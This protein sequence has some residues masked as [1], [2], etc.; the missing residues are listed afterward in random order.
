MTSAE[1]FTIF[2]LSAAIGLIAGL[3]IL[4]KIFGVPIEEPG[5]K[6]KFSETRLFV[7]MLILTFFV[8]LKALN[9][10][11]P[12]FFEFK[13]ALILWPLT[14]RMH[15]FVFSAYFGQIIVGTMFG[16]FCRYWFYRGRLYQDQA[17]TISNSLDDAIA[18]TLILVAVSNELSS[19]QRSKSLL[20]V[21]I[22]IDDD[23]AKAKAIGA[24]AKELEYG[25]LSEAIAEIK[26]IK[27]S[28]V[29]AKALEEIQRRV[30]IDTYYRASTSADLKKPRRNA[31][32]GPK[33]DSRSSEENRSATN[34]GITAGLRDAFSSHGHHIGYGTIALVLLFGGLFGQATV[35]LFDRVTSLS[36]S[37]LE[38]QFA[39]ASTVGE[40][41]FDV[42]REIETK[43][44]LDQLAKLHVS[45]ANH[46][47][48]NAISNDSI[49]FVRNKANPYSIIANQKIRAI[50]HLARCASHKMSDNIIDS[51][52]MR[53][54]LR[55]NIIR[56]KSSDDV[57]KIDERL[58]CEN[59]YIDGEKTS[60]HSFEL[61]TDDAAKKD[62]GEFWVGTS[63]GLAHYHNNE[64]KTISFD[65]N[66]NLD[67][68]SG[69]ASDGM[70]VTALAVG[71]HKDLWIGMSG[72]LARF[73]AGNG[74]VSLELPS[75]S[76]DAIRGFLDKQI[77][78]LVVDHHGDLWVGTSDGLARYQLK[79]EA[80]RLV[81]KGEIRHQ[82]SQVTALALGQ[83]GN[84]WVGTPAGLAI[85][86]VDEGK[87]TLEPIPSFKNEITALSTDEYGDLLI[88]TSEGLLRYQISKN[89][90]DEVKLNLGTNNSP[91]AWDKVISVNIVHN[92]EVWIGTSYGINIAL[93]EGDVWQYIA[94]AHYIQA[95]STLSDFLLHEAKILLSMFDSDFESSLSLLEEA[96]KDEKLKENIIFNKIY[97][98]LLHHLVLES[99]ET[100]DRNLASVEK[101][102]QARIQKIKS[103]IAKMDP[104]KMKG[105]C[106]LKNR[107]DIENLLDVYYLKL[108]NVKNMRAYFLAQG[109]AEGDQYSKAMIPITRSLADE[110][111]EYIRSGS[112]KM[113]QRH[114]TRRLNILFGFSAIQSHTRFS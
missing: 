107:T 114:L 10:W 2:A 38:A 43:R 108:L 88:A 85:V 59:A 13:I 93:K 42:E 102:L 4:K 54:I 49:G 62:L 47:L 16:V 78:A 55:D 31:L 41:I 37:F 104:A 44:A 82:N 5:S 40:A 46:N 3:E 57:G 109:L 111:S 19:Q 90:R 81:P 98:G 105:I 65:N 58:I 101:T 92:E 45:A 11:L 23:Y 60:I 33:E 25:D 71:R 112:I 50:A 26:G 83:N 61:I 72:G 6:A 99:Y 21:A 12:I 14:N 75:D 32:A 67:F 91:I 77:D 48:W 95:R 36:T 76:S 22:A 34:L 89:F 53:H 64:W 73:R 17:L 52:G 110:L 113:D 9:Y 8:L 28:S 66:K 39:K 30:D 100:S 7:A 1:I 103:C 87:D 106:V 56:L 86:R 68:L 18:D 96:D 29:R 74:K 24:I 15:D 20:S 97:L 80:N 69:K 79:E 70:S 51:A 94:D 84:I 35:S 27:N 63:N